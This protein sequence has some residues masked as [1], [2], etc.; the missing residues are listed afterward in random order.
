MNRRE[1][2]PHYGHKHYQADRKQEHLESFGKERVS[3]GIQR[4]VTP[5]SSSSG[6]LP[7]HTP[8]FHKHGGPNVSQG[9]PGFSEFD[10]PRLRREE[11]E[12][13]LPFSKGPEKPGELS[14]RSIE[15]LGQPPGWS[16]TRIT[17]DPGRII[18]DVDVPSTG[19]TLASESELQH[20]FNLPSGSMISS[21]WSIRPMMPSDSK[22]SSIELP[23]PGYSM[24]SPFI[25]GHDIPI[26]SSQPMSLEAIEASMG[27]LRVNLDESTRPSMPRSVP[28]I[29]KSDEPEDSS[30]AP[31]S[32]LPNV[33]S[34]RPLTTIPNY[35]AGGKPPL[36]KEAPWSKVA[37][38]LKTTKSEASS[39]Q[40]I[41]AEQMHEKEESA[42]RVS[43][44]RRF[45]V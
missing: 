19:I 39:L 29:V 38:H 12:K 30:A 32:Q 24:P 33:L 5:L 22:G 27:H 13:R 10:E 6:S 4:G 7:S 45:Y 35:V 40:A 34:L 37:T 25:R 1:D 21:P 18:R 28:K 11:L 3:P 23:L 15:Q 17:M 16:N 20:L 2:I 14:R 41:M 26:R 44:F 42:R 43:Y 9:Y 8:M 31:P 36:S